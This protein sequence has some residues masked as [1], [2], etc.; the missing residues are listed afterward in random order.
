MRQRQVQPRNAKTHLAKLRE[1]NQPQ[2]RSG[3]EICFRQDR[4]VVT[5]VGDFE[6]SRGVARW[7]RFSLAVDWPFRLPVPQ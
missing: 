5:G 7:F 4:Q 6:Q 1:D 3:P 2:R